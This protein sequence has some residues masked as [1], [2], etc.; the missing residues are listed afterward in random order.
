M[1]N[2]F[3]VLWIQKICRYPITIQLWCCQV[4]N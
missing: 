1:I 2:N 4:L 3:N